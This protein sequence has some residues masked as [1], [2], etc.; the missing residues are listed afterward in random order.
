MAAKTSRTALYAPAHRVANKSNVTSFPPPLTP[1]VVPSLDCGGSGIQD[2]RLMWGLYNS[3]TGMA[4]SGWYSSNARTLN[5]VPAAIGA[6]NIAAAANAVSGT[7]VTLAGA[8][9]GITVLSAALRVYPSAN[10]IPANALVLDG[11]PAT[12]NMG[13][14]SIA[15]YYD[16]SSMLGRNVTVT[17]VSGGAG[18]AFTVVGYDIYGEPM[19]ETIT[20]TAGATSVS[21]K[22]AFKF[23]VSI[24]PAF[25]DAH[26]YAFATGDVFGL[27]ILAASFFDTSI[28]W[29]ATA[30]T[31]ST[32]FTAAVTTTPSATTG[33]VRG[34]YAVQSA[35][36]GSKRLIVTQYPSLTS[37]SSL[38]L[39]S[40]LFG[41]VQA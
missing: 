37:M 4:I 2:N 21:G 9:T 11:N 12:F 35:S 27:P 15:G 39:T 3:P 13:T 28:S 18:G 24:T 38:G 19:T 29:A 36:D 30:I 7:A 1:D 8:S 22:K 5:V 32:G 31:A 10:L 34:T 6:G 41:K 20:A 25:S 23:I 14:N 26:T 16:P 40:G 17:G 33:D